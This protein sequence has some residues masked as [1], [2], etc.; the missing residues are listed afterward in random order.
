ME[1]CDV[2]DIDHDLN[3]DLKDSSTEIISS[4]KVDVIPAK[5]VKNELITKT[6]KWNNLKFTHVF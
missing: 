4:Q 2:P 6:K 3:M 5:V 1:G